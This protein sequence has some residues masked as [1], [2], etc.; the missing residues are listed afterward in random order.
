MKLSDIAKEIQNYVNEYGD[1][2]VSSID[3]H[4][5]NM[6]VSAVICTNI[7][8]KVTVVRDGRYAVVLFKS[9]DSS[10]E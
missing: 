8:D 6:N 4:A 5:S 2:N 10:N 1:C 9:N 7:L 3:I